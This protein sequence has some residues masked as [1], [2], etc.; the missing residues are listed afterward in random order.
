MGVDA[1]P[2][3][4]RPIVSPCYVMTH[5]SARGSGQRRDIYQADQGRDH[6]VNAADTCTSGITDLKYLFCGDDDC[7]DYTHL[8]YDYSDYFSGDIS[9][10]DTSSVTDMSHMF[11][12]AEVFN[13]D[14]GSWN[15]SLVTSMEYMFYAAYEFNQDISGWDTSSVRSMEYMFNYAE[16][17]N[18]DIGTGIRAW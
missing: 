10:W 5:Q 2:S 14:I 9:H 1:I 3:A 15:T 12:Y 8:D 6:H 4:L 11:E 17:F 13:E 18:Q 16:A 7:Q